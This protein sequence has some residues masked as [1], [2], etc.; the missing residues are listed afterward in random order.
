LPPPLATARP[1]PSHHEAPAAR[2]P[3]PLR[4]PESFALLVP[5][6]PTR[7]LKLHAALSRRDPLDANRDRC[8]RFARGRLRE[9]NNPVEGERGLWFD[10]ANPW[11]RNVGQ[12][13]D[14]DSDAVIEVTDPAGGGSRARVTLRPVNPVR[15]RD[16]LQDRDSACGERA[17][18]EYAR[19][20]LGHSR[21]GLH[22]PAAHAARSTSRPWSSVGPRARPERSR[23][24]GDGSTEARGLGSPRLRTRLKEGGPPTR[25]T[26]TSGTVDSPKGL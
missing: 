23:R 18:G 4:V 17:R 1:A 26:W 25:S 13:R 12:I 2:R 16:L 22:H 5:R 6:V 21:T 19:G 14:I 9:G 10:R 3:V 11:G 20:P 24:S 15:L 7:V 8:L